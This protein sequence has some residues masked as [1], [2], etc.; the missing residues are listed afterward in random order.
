MKSAGTTDPGGGQTK[1]GD[2][3][4]GHANLDVERAERLLRIHEHGL[5]F[6][7]QNDALCGM[8]REEVDSPAISV[9]VEAHLAPDVPADGGELVGDRGAECGVI[10]IEEPIDLH[11]LPADVPSKRQVH[12]S[13]D[14]ASRA[15][16]QPVHPAALEQAADT[17]SDAGGRGQIRQPPATAMTSGTHSKAEAAIV[18]DRECAVPWLPADYPA[19]TRRAPS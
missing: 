2:D 16:A 5:H 13:G 3:V 17:R 18:H 8:P 6:H 19:I 1:V 4:L 15:D 9:V 14:R 12:G 11:A 10:G 7:D